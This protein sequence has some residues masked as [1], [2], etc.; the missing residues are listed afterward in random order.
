MNYRMLDIMACPADGNFPL[1]VSGKADTLSLPRRPRKLSFPHCQEYCGLRQEHVADLLSSPPDCA[2]CFRQEIIAGEIACPSCRTV[3]PIRNGIGCLMPKSL[4]TQSATT[5]ANDKAKMDEIASRDAQ[6]PDFEK[7]YSSTVNEIEIG[8]IADRLK[9]RKHDLVLDLGAGTGR[10]TRVLASLCSEIV[11]VDMSFES[12]KFCRRSFEK[13]GSVPC[14]CLQADINR[15]PFRNRR[16]FDRVAASQL[17]SC[18]PGLMLR[19]DAYRKVAAILAS[20]GSFV[21]TVYNHT[22]RYP[23]AKVKTGCHDGKLYF[24]RFAPR[25]LAKELGEHFHVQSIVG[26]VSLPQRVLVA[27]LS[28]IG[29]RRLAISMERI[30]ERTR[31]SHWM[32]F[33]LLAKCRVINQ[34]PLR[35]QHLERGAR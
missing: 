21:F 34:D 27:P 9:P 18:L 33:L 1:R 3:F 31:I 32:G 25:E 15:L 7:K 22:T 17:I 14:N 12:L 20:D 35:E 16:L 6:A 5:D 11:A 24:H 2:N 30:V 28:A 26:I 19:R 4:A 23:D 8:A 10:C 29:M 13:Q